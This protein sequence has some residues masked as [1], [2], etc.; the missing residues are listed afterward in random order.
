MRVLCLVAMLLAVFQSALG[1]SPSPVRCLARVQSSVRRA[2]VYA[3]DPRDKAKPK[4]DSVKAPKGVP[5]KQPEA[6]PPKGKAAPPV[7]P[8]RKK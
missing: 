7:A 8:P 3:G 1:F 4:K 2:S 6:P 5:K